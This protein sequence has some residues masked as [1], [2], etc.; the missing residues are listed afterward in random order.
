MSDPQPHGPDGGDAALE[1]VAAMTQPERA[2]WAAGLGAGLA[3]ACDA[4]VAAAERRLAREPAFVLDACEGLASAAVSGGAATQAARALRIASHALAYLGRF[5]EAIAAADRSRGTAAS[6][7]ADVDAARADVASMHPLAK[8]GRPLEAIERGMRARDAM[9]AAGAAAMAARAELNLANVLRL[10]GRHGDALASLDA[11]LAALGADATV[12]GQVQ[13]SRGEVLL[14]LGRIGDSEQAFVESRRLLA[15]DR[16]RFAAGMVTGNLADLNARSGRAGEAI[17]LFDEARS[18]LRAE[19]ALGHVARL[20]AEE[21]ELLE[22]IGASDDALETARRAMA[23]LEPTGHAWECARAEDTM[24]RALLSLGRGADAEVA[25]ERAAARWVRLGNE[26]QARI[27]ALTVSEAA[28]AA[29]RV[30]DALRRAEAVAREAQ[31]PID[32]ARALACA[33]RIAVGTGSG[34]AGASAQQ[35]VEAAERAA[36]PPI[37]ADALESRARANLDAGKPAEAAADALRAIAITESLRGSLQAERLRGAAIGRRTGAAAIAVRAAI[38]TGDAD[39]ALAAI[40]RTRDRALVEAMR[41]KVRAEQ[42]PRARELEARLNELYARISAPPRPGERR[43]ELH[44]W[45]VAIREVERELDRVEGAADAAEPVAARDVRA[46]LGDGE[47][48]LSWFTGLDRVLCIVTGAGRQAI[49]VEC[50][51]AAE[52]SAAAERLGFLLRRPSV[53]GGGPREERLRRSVDESLAAL[54]ALLVAPLPAWVREARRRIVVPH[55]FLAG[56]PFHALGPA[57]AACERET[58]Y[59]PSASAL[60][61]RRRNAADR[62]TEGALVAAVP[63]ALAPEL[64]PEA[65]SI[66][67]TLR[68]GGLET[69]LLVGEQATAG[70]FAAE[71]A[72]RGIVHV[73]THGRFD[74]AHPR[75]SGLRFADRWLNA[76]EFGALPLAGARVVLSGCE[77]GRTAVG[78]G[79]E[80]GGLLRALC[81]ARVAEAVVTLWPVHDAD[82]AGL[83]ARLHALG[84][85]GS[86]NHGSLGLSLHQLQKE[87]CESGL[88]AQRWAPFIALAS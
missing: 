29:G 49:A 66:A 31:D 27:S 10:L 8:A 84:A 13:N 41:S 45:R 38:A 12:A 81:E 26:A 62:R 16:S 1:R 23:S 33:A 55:G 70:A 21:A 72:G 32:A 11:A 80:T 2:S 88:P 24:A 60:V 71:V 52:V 78:R 67:R 25:A 54:H 39:A 53:P 36:V 6:A 56:V 15:G 83:M 85:A 86:A 79:H 44:G 50:G 48:L 57:G 40:E 87:A 47:V 20:E 59:A 35:A 22:A 73:A 74:E 61:E 14:A 7:G 4:A 82:A 76:R 46:V 51:A 42:S 77:T 75:L 65:E 68:D 30:D 28:A 69:A 34:R 58:A 63:D 17:A 18:A 9:R 64:G 5:D 43:V 37:L 3:G 19:G